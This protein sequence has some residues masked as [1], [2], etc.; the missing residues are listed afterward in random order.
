MKK[1]LL[2]SLA[3]LGCAHSPIGVRQMERGAKITERG[4]ER[5]WQDY[6]QYFEN[7]KYHCKAYAPH[8]V[9]VPVYNNGKLARFEKRELNSF[10]CQRYWD[11][12]NPI[13]VETK[14]E[15]EQLLKEIKEL[16][17]K[18]KDFKEKN[19][20][21]EQKVLDAYEADQIMDR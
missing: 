14:Q 4:I 6:L 21:F 10:E 3:I 17:Q 11:L 15:K 13:L 9:V 20:R 2:L 8:T 12:F 5:S 7:V 18:I 19:K 1:I 16:N